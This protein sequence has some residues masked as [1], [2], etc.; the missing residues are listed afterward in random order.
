MTNAVR[1]QVRAWVRRYHPFTMGGDVWR[2]MGCWLDCDGPVDA[3]RGFKVCVVEAPDGS[4]IICEAVSG[5]I[6]GRSLKGVK[7]DIATG[8]FKV[9]KAQV[10]AAKKVVVSDIVEPEEFW[11]VY[12]KTKA[13]A[14][15]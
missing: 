5:G 4:K 7:K 3:G 13:E 10:E 1:T 12:L 8:D 2:P 11:R 6:V 9:M 14:G 15:T